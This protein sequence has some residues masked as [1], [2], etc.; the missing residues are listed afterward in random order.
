MRGSLTR[1]HNYY[2]SKRKSLSKKIVVIFALLFLC[3]GSWLLLRALSG[4]I[5]AIQYSRLDTVQRKRLKL[6]QL[7]TKTHGLNRHEFEEFTITKISSQYAAGTDPSTVADDKNNLS[8]LDKALDWIMADPWVNHH[9]HQLPR[10]SPV[11]LE[12]FLLALVFYVM[13]GDG[14]HVCNITM[15]ADVGKQG[16]H[17][18]TGW[19]SD[20]GHCSGAWR[21]VKCSEEI[22]EHERRVE[23]IELRNNKLE[24]YVPRQIAFF[25]KMVKLELSYN[26]LK[27]GL[28]SEIGRMK[29]LNELRL[30]KNQLTGTIPTSIGNMKGL[31][32]LFLWD[33]HFQGTIPSQIGKLFNLRMLNLQGNRVLSGRIP[34]QIGYLKK[35]QH[36][37]L[38]E[39][40]LTGTIPAS[41][42]ALRKLDVLN[43]QDNQLTGTVPQSVLSNLKE[44]DKARFYCNPK[45]SG[46]FPRKFCMIPHKGTTFV[47]CKRVNCP[48]CT[49]SQPP[50]PGITTSFLF[51]HRTIFSLLIAP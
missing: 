14:D 50:P 30:T 18:T 2:C 1:Y 29:N 24:G 27:G 9:H 34:K 28:P 51:C 6:F 38:E 43:L 46:S 41:F 25:K 20:A 23:T 21:G 8:A 10:R 45:L 7:I 15:A 49:V 3:T 16:W 47:D 37:Y 32:V 22:K 5:K 40:N 19:L 11:Y 31:E 13:G 48:C 12:R 39:N 33:N 26:C 35:L 17:D 44:L 42:K 36:L 4:T